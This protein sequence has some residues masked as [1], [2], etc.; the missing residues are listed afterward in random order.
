M[1]ILKFCE[2][3]K[4]VHNFNIVF[5]QMIVGKIQLFIVNIFDKYEA[6]IMMKINLELLCDVE[7]FLK[8][9]SIPPLFE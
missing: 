3:L 2:M 7:T 6:N 8:S 9:K 1:S 4:H 5:Y